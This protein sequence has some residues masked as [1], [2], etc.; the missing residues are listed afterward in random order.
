MTTCYQVLVKSLALFIRITAKQL[1]EQV[2]DELSLKLIGISKG[3]DN[4]RQVAARSL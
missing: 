1:L 2:I 3:I 4:G